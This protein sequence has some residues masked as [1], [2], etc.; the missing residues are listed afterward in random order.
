MTNEQ[1]ARINELQEIL[2]TT[3]GEET[4]NKAYAEWEELAAIRE[5]EYRRENEPKL[6]AYYNKY[7]KGKTYYELLYTNEWDFYS[8]FHKD[9]YGFRPRGT[10]APG[11]RAWC[12]N[13]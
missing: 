9:V 5:E 10:S 6:I 3:F 11:T 13:N 8:D 1:K 7:I 4:W 2:E 12:E